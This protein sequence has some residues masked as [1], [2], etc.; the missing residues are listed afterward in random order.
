MNR[1]QIMAWLLEGDV[2]VQYQVC[3]DLLGIE[4][5]DI[6]LLLPT[7][8]KNAYVFEINKDSTVKICLE[9][10]KLHFSERFLDVDPKSIIILDEKTF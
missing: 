8:K 9:D 6:H 5:K 3:R 10:T 1:E 2:S 4:K 7:G